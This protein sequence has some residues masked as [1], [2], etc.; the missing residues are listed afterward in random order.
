MDNLWKA[1]VRDLAYSRGLVESYFIKLNEP[2]GAWAAWIKYTFLVRSGRFDPVGE[3][4]FIFFDRRKRAARRVLAAKESFDLQSCRIVGDGTDIRIGANV[5]TPGIC[6]GELES[7]RCSW[8]LS[9]SA[10][11]EPFVLLPSL[12]YSRAAPTTK[13]TTPFASARASGAIRVGDKELSF[14][15]FPMSL[16]HNWG[17]KHTDS[18]V[19]GQ[20]PLSTREGPLFF[21]GCSLPAD[22]AGAGSAVSRSPLLTAGKLRFSGEDISFSGPHSLLAN[23]A[24]VQM[25]QWK[26]EM[27]N[28]MWLLRGE[29]SF[30]PEFVAGLRYLQPDGGVRSCLNS[31]MASARLELHRR[32]GPRKTELV[33]EAATD[34]LAALE[35][36]TANLDHGFPILA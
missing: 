2:T 35:F 4:W 8:K 24:R 6:S 18:Y 34:N 7:G 22:V 32:R 26:F 28:L 33:L 16:G 20:V 31:M 25:G 15:D 10:E 11:G 5:L 23:T 30:E 12:F 13:L 3:C 17:R 1:K 36:L 14:E 27:R 19:W 29:M 21:E 9:F